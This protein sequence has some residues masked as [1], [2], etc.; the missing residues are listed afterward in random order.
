MVKNYIKAFGFAWSG[1]VTFFKT[2]ANARIHAVAAALAITAGFYFDVDANDW[3]W[4]AAAIAAVIV[5]EMLNTAIELLCDYMTTEVHPKI[6]L[7]K[8]I[9]AGAVLIASIFAVV[10]A[11]IIFWPYLFN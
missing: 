3:L 4:I 6:K 8:D 9:S 1:I 10:V 2:E 11:I 7:I 5:S